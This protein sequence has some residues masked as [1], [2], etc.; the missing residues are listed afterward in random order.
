MAE[1]IQ[2]KNNFFYLNNQRWS[3]K[4][5]C[6]QPQDGV[7]PLSDDKLSVIQSLVEGN[8]KKLG[9][10]AVRVYQV[11]PSL[12]HDQVMNYL[13]AN[14]IYVE[15]GAVTGQTAVNASNPQY[16]GSF[17]R[18][19]KSVADAFAK[20]NNVLYFSISN[21][22]ITP[23]LSPGYAIPSI[24]KAAARDLRAYMAQQGYR[25]VPI[26]CAE[27]DEPQYTIPAAAAYVCGPVNERLDILGYNCY[28][29]AGGGLQGQ[30]NAY[31]QLYQQFMF[32]GAT[33]VI[34][35]IMTEFGAN[36]VNPRLFDDIPY[37][38]GNQNVVSNG[39]SVNMA[40][41]F[42]GGFVFR[43]QE[44]GQH[45]GLVDS[46]NNPTSFGGFDNL[47][48]AFQAISSFIAG[49]PNTSGVMNCGVLSGNPYNLPL[50]PTP[51]GGNG[52]PN[53]LSVTVT[54]EVTP[55][56][57]IALTCHIDGDWTTV[58]SMSPNQAPSKAVIPAG[59]TEVQI[60]FKS[61]K[62][63]NWYQACGV[64]QLA[65]LK[66]GATIRGTW[67]EPNGQGACPIS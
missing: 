58:L 56:T 53:D 2:I 11:D 27:R 35:I 18:R 67:E 63:S 7:D 4:G 3:P 48:K 49:T 47:Q 32:N 39:N 26:G 60:V 33:P 22:A 54:N 41:I 64:T 52:I 25:N 5:V 6:Y 40:D 21:E 16:T 34:P 14:N 66:N 29:W 1:I 38:F 20:Y 10:N 46:N 19:I 28:R 62:D 61:T 44:D 57:S 24:I 59:T 50:P 51:G 36:S 13:A 31:Y 17:L 37:L 30:L 12:P 55:G 15:I 43:Y 8:W 65:S 23:G 9:I 45:F 42:S